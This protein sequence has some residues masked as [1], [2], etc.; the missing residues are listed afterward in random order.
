MLSESQERMLLVARAGREDEVIE[1]FKKWELD[2]VVVGWVT[3]SGRV[4]IS[5]EGETVADLPVDLLVEEAP[6]YDRPSARP[7][8]QDEVNMLDLE[9]LPVP[10]DMGEVFKRLI[11][12]PE[13]GDKKWIYRQYDHMIRTNTVVGPGSDSAVLKVKGTNL[14][15]AVSVDCNSRYC[16]LDP[17]LGAMGAVAEA[18]RNVA[19]SGARPLA[20]TDCLNFGNPE[21][22]EVMWQFIRS[23]DGMSEAC[24]VLETPVVSGNV[25]FYN[26]TM[27]KG[28]FPTPTVA[29]VGVIK[30]FSIAVT[31]HFKAEGDMIY[32]L[33]PPLEEESLGGSLYLKEIHGLVRGVPPAVDLAFEKNLHTFLVDGAKRFLFESCH[34]ISEGGFALSLAECAFPSSGEPVGFQVELPY[35][36]IRTDAALFGEAHG[37]VIISVSRKK[38]TDFD[39]FCRE[40]GF[41]PVKIGTTGGDKIKIGA[42]I[43][44]PLKESHQIWKRA[45]EDSLSL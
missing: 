6:V 38:E 20:I 15:L 22:P 29:M 36:G 41:F 12:S 26:E 27:G 17:Y 11:S 14:G 4:R 25:S 31:Q 30:D 5:R 19:V 44:L 43:D 40:S 24:T 39:R 8:S 10:G 9:V 45:F 21:K 2:A 1:I 32:L 37:R 33:G 18:A 28:I 3:D 7:S 35:D 34:D 23:I 13:V 42:Q 16:F